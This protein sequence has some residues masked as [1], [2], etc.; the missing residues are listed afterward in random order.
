MSKVAVIGGGVSGL[1]AM[2][3]LAGEH[4]VVLFEA[5]PRLGG[6]TYTVDVDEDGLELA[7]DLGFIVYN[8]TTYPLF[9]RLLAELGVATQPTTMSFSVRDERDGFEYNGTSLDGLFAQ[10]GNLLRPRMWRMLAGILRFNRRASRL[11]AGD[12]DP[13]LS[14]YL[15]ADGYGGPMVRD[16]LLPM[17]SALWSAEPEEVGEMPARSLITF[18]HHHGML[19]VD[20]RPQWRVLVGGS[21]TYVERLAVRHAGRI[22]TGTAVEW[23]RRR[24]DGVWLTP[25]GGVETRFERVVIATHSDQ[26]LRLLADPSETERAVLGAIPYQRNE[27]VLHTDA[28]FLP[29]SPRARASWNVHL[30]PPRR[31]VGP[32]LT[33]W[34]NALQG[35]G[36]LGARRDYCVTL[37]RTAEIDPAAVLHRAEMAHPVFHHR[38]IAAQRRWDAINGRRGTYFC[39]S[40]WGHG[41]HEDGV[42]SA[43]RVAAALAREVAAGM[44]ASAGGGERH[45]PSWRLPGTAAAVARDSRTEDVV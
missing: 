17:V 37:N 44:S 8:E 45:H 27:V 3:L 29:R 35:L 32:Q 11:L 24:N 41:F 5:A 30:N 20:D 36:V 25:R 28:R 6:H 12:A 31:A 39:G 22:V 16:Y 15:A 21:R 1:V 42:R 38:T 40:Y 7:I 34:M 13:T 2:H 9:T 14:E 26:A 18:L 33:Y 43:H 10:R 23:I 19:T 4:E